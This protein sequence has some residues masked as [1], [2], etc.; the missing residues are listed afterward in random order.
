MNKFLEYFNSN[1]LK[2]GNVLNIGIEK[3]E[4]YFEITQMQISNN[5]HLYLTISQPYGYVVAIGTNLH[6][7]GLHLYQFLAIDYHNIKLNAVDKN[8]LDRS[9]NIS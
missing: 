4:Q 2:I 7:L 1:K 6:N 9:K 3:H 8:I 5:Q